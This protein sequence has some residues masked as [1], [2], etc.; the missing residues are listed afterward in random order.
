MERDCL[1]KAMMHLNNLYGSNTLNPQVLFYD[2]HVSHFDDRVV[3]ILL[4]HYI[5]PFIHKAVDSGNGHPNDDV[6]NLKLK[7]LYVQA[8]MN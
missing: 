6:P 7:G 8:I 1:M 4:S 5:K 2:G 3:L